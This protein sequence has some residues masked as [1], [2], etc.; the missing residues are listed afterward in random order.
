M[1]SSTERAV[2]VTG[3]S[4]GIG[5]A[6]ATG[7]ARDGYFVFATVRREDHAEE[8]R[9]LGL[10]GLIPVCPL[11]L[12]CLSDIPPARDAVTAELSRRGLEGLYALVNNAGGSAVAPVELLS[13]ESLRREL[14]ARILGSVAMVQSFLPLIRLARGRMVWIVTPAM[15]PTPFVTSIHACDFAVNCVARTLEMELKPWDIPNIMVRCGGI[16]TPAGLRTTAEVEALLAVGPVDGVALY[17]KALRT[18]AQE[19][20]A[21]DRKRTE[22]EEVVA[23]VSRLLSARS[24]RRRYSVGYLSGAAALLAALPPSITDRILGMRFRPRG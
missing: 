20:A 18:W 21:F 7:L 13:L 10:P 22:P 9:R 23:V 8:L 12:T 24:P 11:D 4:S 5:R 14:L 17:E 2:L 15:I 1:Q 16:R 19:M 3:C 6:V